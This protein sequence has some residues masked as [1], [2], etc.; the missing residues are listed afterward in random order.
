[1]KHIKTNYPRIRRIFL[2]SIAIFLLVFLLRWGYEIVFFRHDILITAPHTGMSFDGHSY[3]IRISNIATDQVTQKAITGES[4]VIDQKYEKTANIASVSHRFDEDHERLRALITAHDA[5]VQTENLQGL[6]GSQILTMTIGVMPQQFDDM[7]NSIRALGTLQSFTVNRVDRTNEF[8]N[9]LAHQEVL[10]KTRESYATLQEMGG[11]IQ[12]MLLLQERILLVET[13]L[14]HLG[15]D[16]G[17]FASEHSFCTINFSLREQEAQALSLQFALNGAA[18]S[19]W[20]TLGA[21]VIVSFAIIGLLGV[22]VLGLWLRIQVGK[23][24]SKE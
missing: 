13:E 10:R 4:I 9:L 19:F 6:P 23:L 5:M 21:A 17:V 22:A 8:N 3:R 7:V 1:M 24:Q 14:Q 15:V 18:T 16:L 11:S 20:W 2:T 12:D